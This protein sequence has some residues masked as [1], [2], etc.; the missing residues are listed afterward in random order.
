MSAAPSTGGLQPLSIQSS[1]GS[2]GGDDASSTSSSSSESY[3][4]ASSNDLTL[5]SGAMLLTADCMGTGILALPADVQN[6]G[7]VWGLGFLLLNLPINL[8]AGTILGRCAL[9]VEE[10]I[11]GH[12]QR[13]VKVSLHDSDGDAGGELNEDENGESKQGERRRKGYSSVENVNGEGHRLDAKSQHHTDTATFDFV[14]LTS[15]LFDAPILPSTADEFVAE[16]FAI[17]DEEEEEDQRPHRHVT[18][19][20]PFTKVVLCIYYLNLFLVLGNYILV[21]SHAVSAMAGEN[22]LC[23]PTAG[24][25]ASTIMYG[26][27]QLR[28]M[29]HLGRSVS[30]V[31][32]LALLIVVV[33]CLYSLRNADESENEIM[34][35]EE[36]EYATYSAAE[37]ALAKMS[38][39]AAIAF[40]VGSQKLL[41]NI[42]HEMSDRKKAAPGSLSIALSTYG[43]AYLCVCLLAGPEPPSFLFDAIPEGSLGRRIAGLLLWI[44]VAVSYAINSQ[45]LCSSLDR[46]VGQSVTVCGLERKH[47]ARWALLTALVASSSYLVANAVPFFK[48]LVALCGAATSIPLTLLI[49]AIFYR[50]IQGVPLCFP[51]I[52]SKYSFALVLFSVL[53]MIIGL[54][55]ALGSI[56]VD[57]S[58]KSGPFACH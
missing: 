14:G 2:P 24:L 43:L 1:A 33:Q 26:L 10:R 53:F 35:E 32:L 40:A 21:M 54:S 56:D 4:D 46:A 44:H 3:V 55:G 41:L 17:D 8:Y 25:I 22:N 31:S 45:A 5:L 38:S 58:N 50:R 7:I 27:S 12:V 9:Y 13:P 47:R 39:L 37:V 48:D 28:T 11:L 52:N 6:L 20:H 42:R 36:A 16:A 30:A 15:M 23:I 18:F 51:T 49:P 29:T 19:D 34:E 57:W